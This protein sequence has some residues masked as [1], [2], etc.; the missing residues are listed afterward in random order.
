MEQEPSFPV[1][2]KKK[3]KCRTLQYF[4]LKPKPEL[5]SS[6]RLHL[7]VPLFICSFMKTCVFD[8]GI[9]FLKQNPYPRIRILL[10]FQD[11][12]CWIRVLGFRTIL[13]Y[14]TR[15]SDSESFSRGFGFFDS[16]FFY[17]NLLLL[18]IFDSL[19]LC[20]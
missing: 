8:S 3:N 7:S 2:K 16:V 15:F 11:P 12:L 5:L 19:Q 20:R 6:F 17:F 9:L 13:I 1:C 4:Q 14:Q 18:L 10:E